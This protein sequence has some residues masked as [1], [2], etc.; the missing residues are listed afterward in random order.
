MDKNLEGNN[1]KKAVALEGKT[2]SKDSQQADYKVIRSR[3]TSTEVQHDKLLALL[4]QGPQTTYALRK[5]GIA[6]TSTRIF[7]LRE[8]GHLINTE[9]VQAF[10][11]DGFL[12]VGVARYTLLKEAQKQLNL[13]EAANDE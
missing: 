2:A 10:D 6:Q 4:R 11:S 9:R 7:E 13:P 5:N 8:E 3:S 1:K 12:H